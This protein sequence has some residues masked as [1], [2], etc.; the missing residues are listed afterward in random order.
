MDAVQAPIIP[1]IGAP[2][3]PGAGHHFARPGGGALRAA[4][5]GDRR[6]RARARTDPATHEY[7]DGAGHRRPLVERS[8]AKLPA[9][10][11]IDVARGS[12]IMVTAG[13]NM[14]FMHAVLAITAPGDEII[15]PVPFYFNHEMAIEMA[16]C[17]RRSRRHRRA[18]PARGSTRSRARDHRSHA[19]DRH[20]LAEQSERRRASARQRFATVNA[21][22]RE[23]G[24]YHIA[25]EAYEYFTYGSA[26]ARVAGVVSRRGGPHDLDVLAVEG[27]RVCRLAH[28][29]HDLSRSISSRR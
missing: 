10:N 12:R 7:S 3:P 11:G 28:R 5:G 2:D 25:D 14:A 24:I 9:E 17:T 13:A 20:D 1:V 19:R 26:R 15:L 22:C 4:A 18:L 16:G 6:R 27:V 23:R 29:L 8:R 21:L